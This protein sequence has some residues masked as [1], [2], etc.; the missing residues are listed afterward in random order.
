MDK[1]MNNYI[2]LALDLEK[3]TL[4]SRFHMGKTNLI[5]INICSN[6]YCK[7]LDFRIQAHNLVV[8]GSRENSSMILYVRKEQLSWM[9]LI[10]ILLLQ[11]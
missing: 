3:P 11:T 7:A 2:V 9:V 4:Q 10:T 1:F 5:S 8:W 6:I